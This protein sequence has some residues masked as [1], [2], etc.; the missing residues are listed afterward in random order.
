MACNLS[1]IR[2]FPTWH[3]RIIF[4]SLNTNREFATS[5]S[6]LI[7]HAVNLLL[8]N[9]ILSLSLYTLHTISFLKIVTV[10]RPSTLL[11][12]FLIGRSRCPTKGEI[13]GGK[14]WL[15]AKKFELTSSVWYN[16]VKK[17]IPLVPS[18]ISNSLKTDFTKYSACGA[19][20]QLHVHY[21]FEKAH[22]N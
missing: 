7:L 15:L 1:L 20:F 21:L 12:V 18:L 4:S 5:T 3:G 22:W 19:N 6:P 13:L 9:K 14:L 11:R 8:W 10:G 2:C 16:S 17:L